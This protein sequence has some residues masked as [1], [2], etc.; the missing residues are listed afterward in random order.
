VI[1]TGAFGQRPQ[2]AV[3]WPVITYTANRSS[4]IGEGIPPNGGFASPSQV[5][6]Q[7][8]TIQTVRADWTLP[9]WRFGYSMNH[10]F[11]DNRQPGRESSDLGNFVQGVTVS[12]SV[13]SS[14][15]VAGD[16]NLER[17]TNVALNQLTETWRVGG[18]VNWRMT[19]HGTLNALGSHTLTHV[20]AVTPS[21]SN[22]FNIQYSYAFASQGRRLAKPRAQLFGRSSWLSSTVPNALTNS[23]DRRRNWTFNTGLSLSVF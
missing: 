10:S 20:T 7:L 17:A 3:W 22:N 9:H 5:P 15:D 19:S 12:T 2:T 23:E 1:P 13:G 21:Q 4:Q 11:V 18:N 16:L 14:I 8:N 6:N